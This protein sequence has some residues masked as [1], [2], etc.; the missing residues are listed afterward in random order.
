MKI[1]CIATLISAASVV[2]VPPAS[3]QN[4]DACATFTPDLAQVVTGSPMSVKRNVPARSNGLC[5]YQDATGLKL[6]GFQLWK[7]A[8]PDEAS[9]SMQS[10]M[11]RSADA[12]RTKPEAVAG[13]GDEAF[14][15]DVV[16]ALFVRKGSTWFGFGYP[17]RQ[18]QIDAARKMLGKL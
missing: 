2:I 10:S 9:K 17:N 6:V 11:N 12:V 14:Y 16:M 8:S 5:E 4:L 7:M 15:V 1:A 18:G 13:L 3:A